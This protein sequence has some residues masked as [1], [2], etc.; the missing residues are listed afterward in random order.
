MENIMNTKSIAADAM[1]PRLLLMKPVDA[2]PI[3]AIVS[4]RTFC[5]C[6]SDMLKKESILL[7][8]AL[9]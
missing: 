6:P 1:F 8:M 5:N 3:W 9:T 2:L 7:N 4:M